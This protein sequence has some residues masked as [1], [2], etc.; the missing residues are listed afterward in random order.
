VGCG[1]GTGVGCG[2]GGA[3]VGCGVGCGGV[4]TGVGCGVGTGVGNALWTLK[5]KQEMKFSVRAAP[6]QG[7]NHLAGARARNSSNTNLSVLLPILLESV[8]APFEFFQIH[9][10][11]AFSVGHE[12]ED[13]T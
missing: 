11:T 5:S 2:V 4:G 7:C 10:P 9:L 3:G 1:V 8:H 12:K 13:G 6:V